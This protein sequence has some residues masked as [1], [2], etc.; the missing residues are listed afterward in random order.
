MTGT[1]QQYY[2]LTV[3]SVTSVEYADSPL[4][5]RSSTHEKDRFCVTSSWLYTDPA[6]FIK[7]IGMKHLWCLVIY[8]QSPKQFIM[9]YLQ[10]YCRQQNT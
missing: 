1:Q 10:M 2:R 9:N 5:G 8:S 7:G 6:S 3:V 4:S